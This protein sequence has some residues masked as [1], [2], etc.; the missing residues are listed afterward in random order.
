MSNDR[1]RMIAICNSRAL[2]QLRRRHQD[3]YSELLQKAY[4]D[5]GLTVRP[6]LSG[7]ALREDRIA[8]HKAALEVLE[9][10]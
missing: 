5:A 3:E 7:S 4:S 10:Q 9:I 6:R 8:K 2:Q 1:R